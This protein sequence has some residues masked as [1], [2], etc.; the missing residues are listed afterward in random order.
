VNVIA[1]IRTDPG[2]AAWRQTIFHPFALTSRHGR[3]RVLRVEPR[4]PVHLTALLGEV[5]LLDATA[6]LDEQAGTVALFAVNRDQHRPMALDVDARALPAAAAVE[7]LAVF[8]SDPEAVNDAPAPDRVTPVHRPAPRL[9]GGRFE[10][11]LPPLSWSLLRL[12]PAD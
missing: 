11:L 10:V 8:A 1:P 9:D 5:P 3:G 2:G 4:G 7:H 12:L 6:V